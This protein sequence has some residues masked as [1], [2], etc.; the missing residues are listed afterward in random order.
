MKIIILCL[1]LNIFNIKNDSTTIVSY[2]SSKHHG[3]KTASGKIF[4]MNNLTAAHKTLPFGTKVKITN[5]KNNKSVVVIIN[6]R[7]PFVKNRGFDLSKSAFKQI[8]SLKYGKIKIK[9][10]FIDN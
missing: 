4:N 3:K 1:I 2:Y 9:Y 8:S 7:G 6:D 5:L 10:N